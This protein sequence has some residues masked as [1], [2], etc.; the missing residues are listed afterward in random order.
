MKRGV[1]MIKIDFNDYSEP[2]YEKVGDFHCD[3]AFVK[4]KKTSLYGFIDR[5]GEEV[6]PC[7]YLDVEDFSEDLAPVKT[8]SGWGYIDKLGNIAITSNFLQARAFFCGLAVV[9]TF[10]KTWGYI[11]KKGELIIGELPREGFHCTENKVIFTR[12]DGEC[13]CYDGKSIKS[14]PG[15]CIFPFSEGY[16]ITKDSNDFLIIDENLNVR[17]RLSASQARDIGPSK[18]GLFRLVSKGGR[19][20]YLNH[21]FNMQI[22]FMYKS[23]RDFE[24]GR[25][26]V[27]LTDEVF[28]FIDPD[29]IATSF[30]KNIQYR[31]LDDYKE[32]LARVKS[33]NGYG[34]INQK[35]KSIIPCMRINFSHFSEGLVA[36]FD[37]TKFIYF[38]ILGRQ[39]LELPSVY[40]STLS[41]F[42]RNVTLKAS[43]KKKLYDLKVKALEKVK[44]E[45]I[46]SLEMSIEHIAQVEKQKSE[47]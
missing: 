15:S 34:F 32:N 33:S 39:Q 19:V 7:Q 46:Q 37:G 21:E 30:M 44:Q 40:C 28:G 20:G 14:M 25:A 12:S 3:H 35:G 8:E 10:D 11:D 36:A 2:K 47:L 18:N 5:T 27:E 42:D 31:E 4:D 22:P 17:Y 9:Q 38:D 43:S 45:F 16:A 29:G 1:I 41:Y 6:I 24:N 23:G 13:L 26:Y